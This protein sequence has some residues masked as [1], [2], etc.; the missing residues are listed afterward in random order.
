MNTAY[1]DTNVILRFLTGDPPEMAA[2]AA[3]LFQA[4]QDKK[5]TVQVD[6]IVIA[7][8]V[9]VLESFYHHPKAD[10]AA[11]LRDFLLQDGIESPDAETL[12]YALTLYETKNID[13]TD[14]LI[15]ARMEKRRIKN[16]FSFDHHFDRLPAI[17]R[18][19]PGDHLIT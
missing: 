14:A 17:Q 4:V 10:I 16:L 1:I 3:R 13:F 12:L 6:D 15:A 5:L 8:A 18:L 7:E 11:T 19:S 2:E 9:W